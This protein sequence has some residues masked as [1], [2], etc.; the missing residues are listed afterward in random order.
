ME[1]TY[2]LLTGLLLR[3]AVEL[4]AECMSAV[5]AGG[6]VLDVPLAWLDNHGFGYLN[7]HSHSFCEALRPR[8]VAEF[9]ADSLNAAAKIVRNALYIADEV[10]QLDG[11]QALEFVAGWISGAS[12][13]ALGVGPGFYLSNLANFVPV[14]RELFDR[15]FEAGE[16]DA[17]ARRDQ[18]RREVSHV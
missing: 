12:L 5:E 18:K 7:P 11:E 8:L 6:N 14:H 15:G 13:L 1:K 2:H 4:E 3:L 9:D 17:I 16:A 10:Q